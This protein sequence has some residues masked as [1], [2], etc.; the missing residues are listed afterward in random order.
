MHCSRLLLTE[1]PGEVAAEWSQGEQWSEKILTKQFCIG[2]CQI[3][4]TLGCINCDDTSKEF[5]VTHPSLDPRLTNSPVLKGG[6]E[7]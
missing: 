1:Q 5:L 3:A 6:Q 7:V 2:K 4:V